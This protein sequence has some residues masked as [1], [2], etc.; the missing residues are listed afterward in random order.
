LYEIIKKLNNKNTT[1]EKYFNECM[2]NIVK[3]AAGIV[4]NSEKNDNVNV[5]IFKRNVLV[6][7][8]EIICKNFGLEKT[9]N[10]SE[11]NKKSIIGLYF[12]FY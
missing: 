5:M 10:I 6:V 3:V 8:S 9:N 11:I 12:F 4:C 7:L 1:N 2:M